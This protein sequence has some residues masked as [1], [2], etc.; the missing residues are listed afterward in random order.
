MPRLP[1]DY[2]KTIIYKI[3]CDDLPEFIYIGSTANF[4]ERKSTHKKKCKDHNSKLYQ[5]IRENGG[6][7][8]WKMIEVERFTECID[9]NDA[10]KREQHFMDEFKSNLN[11]I[12]AYRTEEQFLEKNK[13]YYEKNKAQVI[14]QK[15]EYYADNKDK[16]LLKLSQTFTCECGSVCRISSKSTHLKSKKHI[17]YLAIV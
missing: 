16:I 12:K 14:Q 17:D 9:G 2:S 1:V 7:E 4:R 3:V 6:F 8:N 11:M 5:T 10:R 15:K 13:I